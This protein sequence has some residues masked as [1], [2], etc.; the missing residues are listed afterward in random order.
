MSEKTDQNAKKRSSLATRVITAVPLVVMLIAAIA[1]GGWVMAAVAF[2]CIALAIYEE[3][4]ALRAGGHRPVWWVSFAG[5][6][7]ALPLMMKLSFVGMIPLMLVLCLCVVFQVMRREN[8]DLIDIL[9]SVLP[10]FTLVLP[11]MCIFGV[12]DTQ[13]R[14]LELMLTV[15]VF[16]TAV[17]G[18]TFAYFVG[19]AVGGPKLCPPISPNKTIA[20]SI[21]GLAGSMAVTV[22]AGLI[23]RWCSP[24]FF[25]AYPLI[26]A[27]ALV[28]LVGGAAAQLGDLFASL[29]KRHCKIKD[30]GHIFPGHGGMMDR[31][32]SVLFTAIVI[33]CYRVILLGI[34]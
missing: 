34:A 20:G 15:F 16:T 23:F 32:D 7:C 28:G 12:V 14:T 25:S 11:A 4:G 22:L 31:L 33:Y 13:P 1:F 5:L 24:E 6:I 18:D 21:G 9:V 10:L 3:L 8:P 29:I 27:D 30:F 19:S 17:G 2:A 26:W